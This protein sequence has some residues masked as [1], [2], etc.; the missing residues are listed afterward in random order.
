LANKA[1][2]E[3]RHH[4]YTRIGDA[5]VVYSGIC[6]K[7]T[8]PQHSLPAN[9]WQALKDRNWS[10]AVLAELDAL[11]ANGTFTV[12]PIPADQPVMSTTFVF[13]RKVNRDDNTTRFKARFCVR[14]YEEPDDGSDCF[15]PT[16]DNTNLRALVALAAAKR[17]KFRTFDVKSAFTEA[18]IHK[19]LFI[20]PPI[21]MNVPKGYCLRLDK[22]LY[23]LRIAALLFYLHMREIL[24]SMGF[25]PSM[26]SNSIF[27]RTRDGVTE[28]INLYVDD[29]YGI[30][31]SDEHLDKLFK[32]LRSHI[33]LQEGSDSNYVGLRIVSSPNGIVIHQQDKIENL[34]AAYHVQDSSVSSPWR[35]NA[36]PD[37][38][39]VDST[40]YRS[41]V[42][43]LLY[44]TGASR[45]DAHAAVIAC[46]RRQVNP[47]ASDFEDA[48]Q[49]LKYLS[50]T[51][52]QSLFYPYGGTT[53]VSAFSD[54]NLAGERDTG[55]STHDNKG[56]ARRG[57]QL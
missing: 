9:E 55:R 39:P 35:V 7:I 17:W 52:S 22:T 5:G 6:C 48:L 33:N 40:K 56:L 49:I 36:K 4:E 28:I 45:P 11:A 14:G 31:P 25:R 34:A 21:A 23:G 57:S 37:D 54:S 1:G 13:K 16:S 12:V 20:R 8:D 18:R 27:H 42:G 44:I 30:A 46:S 53:S 19:P 15:A 43:S 29:L 3:L 32:E 47:T 24:H 38:T 10:E 41:L 51:K 2:G 50:S 26:A